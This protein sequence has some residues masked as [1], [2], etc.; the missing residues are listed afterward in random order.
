MKWKEFLAIN[1]K[2]MALEDKKIEEM[3]EVKRQKEKEWDDLKK[4]DAD[5]RLKKAMG[6]LQKTVIV[7]SLFNYLQVQDLF[8]YYFQYMQFS[9]YL[10]QKI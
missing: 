7:M 8:M 2:F 3:E 6:L 10:K 9:K 5:R 4:W 1:P